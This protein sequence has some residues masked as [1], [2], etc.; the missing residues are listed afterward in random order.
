M[1]Q[2]SDIPRKA[3]RCPAWAT[4]GGQ[5]RG[6][7]LVDLSE[8]GAGLLFDKPDALPESFTLHLVNV[9]RIAVACHLVSQSGTQ[10]EVAFFKQP[11]NATASDPRRFVGSIA[12]S[13]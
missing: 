4:I 1:A 12:I 13:V 7:K 6:C 9:Q 11:G 8:S 10:V 2:P 5:I 3:F